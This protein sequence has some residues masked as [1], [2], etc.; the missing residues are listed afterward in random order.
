MLLFLHFKA[1]NFRT[2]CQFLRRRF[3]TLIE[4]LVVIAIIAILASMLLPALSKARERARRGNCLSNLKQLGLGLHMYT[5]DYDN[6]VP[7]GLGGD[8]SS[9]EVFDQLLLPYVSNNHK[10]FHCPADQTNHSGELPRSYSTMYRGVGRWSEGSLNTEA[11]PPLTINRWL[12]GC[13]YLIDYHA[14]WNRMGIRT[15]DSVVYVFTWGLVQRAYS[16]RPDLFNRHANGDNFL[17]IDGRAEWLR[18]NPAD[19]ERWRHTR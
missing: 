4:L 18:Y 14:G 5:M 17:F 11:A 10:V 8:G 15:C 7:R 12:P 2:A 1:G 9:S 19:L 6:Y 3:F 13:M 16:T